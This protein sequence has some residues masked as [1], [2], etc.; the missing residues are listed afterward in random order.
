MIASLLAA[1]AAI[2]ACGSSVDVEAGYENHQSLGASVRVDPNDKP[3][4]EVG[5]TPNDIFDGKTYK[6]EFRDAD[7][8]V[9]SSGTGTVAAGTEFNQAIP[10]GATTL[11]LTIEGGG[12]SQQVQA[13]LAARGPQIGGP[14]SKPT[15]SLPTPEPEPKLFTVMEHDLDGILDGV[16][17]SSMVVLADNFADAAQT[18]YDGA[19]SVENPE[20]NPDILMVGFLWDATIMLDGSVC[21]RSWQLHDP[22]EKFSLQLNGGTYSSDWF[23]GNG[24][25]QDDTAVFQNFGD[26]SFAVTT[27]PLSETL[28]HG[29]SFSHTLVVDTDESYGYVNI[30]GS[31]L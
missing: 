14:I 21:F 29:N 11:V 12:S 31:I 27:I 1:S 23:F 20:A 19:R 18:G 4:R 24:S 7:G 26:W 3:N 10:D 22:I 13:A 28:P 2:A 16:L 17:A 6:F 8:N 15:R 25:V 30:H 5:V 9:L